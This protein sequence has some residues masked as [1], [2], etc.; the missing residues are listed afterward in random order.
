MPVAR[1]R[2][3]V[4]R[5]AWCAVTGDYPLGTTCTHTCGNRQCVRPSHMVWRIGRR[6][7]LDIEL[8]SSGYDLDGARSCVT[9]DE[10][11]AAACSARAGQTDP[12]QDDRLGTGTLP[13]MSLRALA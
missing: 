10:E 1:R 6:A 2:V 12:C 8:H 7:T 11:L 4:S 9:A 13:A 5:V 3:Q